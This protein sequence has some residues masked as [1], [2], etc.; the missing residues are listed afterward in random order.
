LYTVT[1]F[2]HEPEAWN[3]GDQPCA[4]LILDAW[5]PLLTEVERAAVRIIG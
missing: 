3:D 4:I 2:L 1:V 5:N